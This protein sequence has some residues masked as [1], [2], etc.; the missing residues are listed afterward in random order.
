MKQKIRISALSSKQMDF[1]SIFDF[2][3]EENKIEPIVESP[4]DYINKAVTSKQN[5]Q[6]EKTASP[7][8][9]TD[10]TDKVLSK[11][12]VSKLLNNQILHGI[13]FAAETDYLYTLKEYNAELGGLVL[14]WSPEDV[15]Q[16]YLAAMEESLETIRGLVFTKSLYTTDDDENIHVNPLLEAETRWYMSESFELTCSTHGLEACE[17]RAELKKCLYENT[18]SHVSENA[19]LSKYR[20]DKEVILHDCKEDMGWDIFFDENYLL[21]EN[22]LAVKW[23]DR[24]I[25]NVYTKAFRST[26]DLF[27]ELV[28]NNKLT[29]RNTSGWLTVN[30]TFERQFDWIMSEVFE[31][32]GT[33]LGY[34]VPAVRSQIATACEM[35]FY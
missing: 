29:I 14:D 2:E 28:V 13:S 22:K 12:V 32:V 7:K 33:H 35:T 23:T 24:D 31:I 27:E 1:F 18:H 30:P 15:Y 9:G 5:I 16:L 3:N 8:I 4:F 21:S 11:P 34:N 25:M 20:K 26:I 17:F 6:S 10:V 19:K